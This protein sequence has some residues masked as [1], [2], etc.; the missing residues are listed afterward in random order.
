[1]KSFWKNDQ[2]KSEKNVQLTDTQAGV[3]P[4]SA[5]C[6][7]LIILHQTIQEIINDKKT[8]HMI[9]LNVHKAY[10]KAWL[11]GIL[12]ALHLNAVKGIKTVNDQE[13]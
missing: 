6:D 3:I 1:M 13:I 10:N 2:W 7:H 5:T 9:F 11:H 8:A 12:H 4:G